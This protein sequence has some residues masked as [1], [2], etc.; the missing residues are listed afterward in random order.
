MKTALIAFGA[1]FALLLAVALSVPVGPPDPKRGGY[2]PT[3]LQW[4]TPLIIGAGVALIALFCVVWLA[5]AISRNARYASRYQYED[6]E[7]ERETWERMVA[8]QHANQ[9]HERNAQYEDR[10]KERRAWLERERQIR[11]LGERGYRLIDDNPKYEPLIARFDN[12]GYQLT[13]ALP[14]SKYGLEDETDYEILSCFTLPTPSTSR[15]W[16]DLAPYNPNYES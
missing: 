2:S 13:E 11:Q 9:L 16:G 5:A 8:Q 1:M 10:E 12:S 3:L 7:K 14:A 4:G 15:G 6:R